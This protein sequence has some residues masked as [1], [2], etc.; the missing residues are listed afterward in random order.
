[1]CGCE[2][3][4]FFFFLPC[5]TICL[6]YFS[7]SLRNVKALFL[8]LWFNQSHYATGKRRR[9]SGRVGTALRCT[10]MLHRWGTV[11]LQRGLTALTRKRRQQ[12]ATTHSWKRELLRVKGERTAL[13]GDRT[14]ISLVMCAH[15]RMQ[16]LCRG[17]EWEEDDEQSGFQTNTNNGCV[18]FAQVS[19]R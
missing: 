14:P 18:V 5:L 12:R 7:T 6:L 8:L 1:M 16:C 10:R 4:F 17:G 15:E 2:L 9:G 13:T 11:K 3:H 19:L